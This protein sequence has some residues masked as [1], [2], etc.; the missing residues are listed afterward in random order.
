MLPPIHFLTGWVISNTI[1]QSLNNRRLCVLM[2]IIPDVDAF[3]PNMKHTFGH[4]IIFCFAI[5]ILFKIL[6]R[7]RISSLTLCF[8]SFLSHLILDF[9]AI[10][11]KVFYSFSFIY[12]F[13]FFI[14][15]ETRYGY[16]IRDYFN[17]IYYLFLTLI[18]LFLIIKYKRTPI[19]IFSQRLD[20]YFVTILRLKK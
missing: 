6:F 12:P 13:Q 2:S 18:I 16:I 8:I 1:P 5:L 11:N 7:M 9:I 15:F 3:I 14:S 19:D 4:S 17:C 20:D 10:S